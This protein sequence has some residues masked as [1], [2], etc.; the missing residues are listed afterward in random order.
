M[1]DAQTQIYTVDLGNGHVADIEGPPGATPEQLQAALGQQMPD[2]NAERGKYGSGGFE[3]PGVPADNGGDQGNATG[4][5]DPQTGRLT[6]NI[7][8]DQKR[9][10]GALGSAARGAIDG[11]TLGFGD[12]IHGAASGVGSLLSGG[13]FSSAYNDTV[14]SDGE[15]ARA[16]Q[17]QH[18]YARIAGELAGGLVIPGVGEG[19]GLTRGLSAVAS[20]A[21]RAARLEGFAADEARVIA[22]RTIARRVA[23]E[24]AAYG[25]AYGAGSADGGPGERLTGALEGAAAGG[26]GGAALGGAGALLA[27][28]S[29]AARQA[30]R[31]LPLSEE[32]KLYRA[33]QAEGIDLLPADYGSDRLRRMTAGTVQTPYGANT[34]GRA[35]DQTVSQFQDRVGQLA[36]DA[37]SPDAGGAILRQGRPSDAGESIAN[38]VGDSLGSS[39]DITGAGQLL[40]RGVSRFMDDTADRTSQ[41]YDRIPIEPDQPA[42]LT[43]TRKVLSDLTQA[44]QSN[45]DLGAMFRN[46]RFGRYLDALTPKEVVQDGPVLPGAGKSQPI[47]TMEGG[48]LSWNDLKEFRTQIGDALAS[49]QL[50]PKIAPRQLRALYGAL[51]ED[52]RATAKDVSPQAYKAWTRA[53]DFADGRMKR[54]NDTLSLLVGDRK[55]KTPNEAFSTVQRLLQNNGSG[56]FANLGRVLRSLPADD[57][58]T[59]RATLVNQTAGGKTFD[60]EA[61]S[62]A[63]GG[64]SDRAKS[65]LLPGAGQRDLMDQAASRAA[66]V[67][68]DPFAGKSNEQVFSAFANMARD[69][70]NIARFRQMFG[71]LS[72][73]EQSTVRATM[74][75]R[76]GRA[77]DSRQ[78]AEG[79]A[80]SIGTFLTNW[81]KHL[82]DDAKATLFGHGELRGN[83][84]NLARIA[85]QVKQR[86]AFGGFSNTG[87]INAANL[88]NGG[89]AS[90]ALAAL[91]GHPLVAAGLVTPAISQKVSAEVLTSPRLTRWLVAASRKPNGNAALAHIQR[92]GAIARAEPAIA[93]DVL[94]IQQRLLSAIQPTRAAASD[95]KGGKR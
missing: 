52:M 43:N 45:P 27:D 83:L 70:G 18:P 90:A 53:N 11:A 30:A 58:A 29:Y 69:N 26:I 46:S 67:S 82:S 57:A 68:R 1:T 47:T 54:I 33:A 81:N 31:A 17:A 21:Y 78:N 19:V 28:R 73:E 37:V 59:V 92:L 23:A 93:N 20:D 2:P 49:P 4:Y 14:A 91:S 3:D 7:Y 74:I 12:E 34:I 35:A 87:A 62:K 16:D 6:V 61:F 72:P 66:A 63:W 77:V 71:G 86:E 38:A 15:Q 42:T 76:L 55:D 88:T 56:D 39:T 44:W 89:L 65:Y 9:E 50:A 94:G 5:I 25:G 80:F 60:P 79:D 36:G 48:Q 10:S 8:G 22:Q 13:D 41:L 40:Q 24:G 64:L 85:D 32:Q 75:D 95:D 51:S 84:D